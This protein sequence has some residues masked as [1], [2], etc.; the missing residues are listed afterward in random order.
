MPFCQS[1]STHP[2][3]SHCKAVIPRCLRSVPPAH[4]LLP[5]WMSDSHTCMHGRFL[6]AMFPSG[7]IDVSLLHAL[8]LCD[9]LFVL[10]QLLSSFRLVF[11][12]LRLSAPVI[13]VIQILQ[14]QNH[15]GRHWHR[16][17][18]I[19]K[20]PVPVLL[21]P[22]KANPSQ[23]WILSPLLIINIARCLTEHMI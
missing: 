17:C 6:M 9:P 12:R 15:E 22:G 4:S 1:N 5:I 16:F 20:A 18:C 11:M 13:I 2:S 8:Y 23:S 19:T 21:K 7:T 3:K 14:K 10:S